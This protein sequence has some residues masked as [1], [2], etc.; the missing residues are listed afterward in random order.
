[1]REFPKLTSL[2]G[3]RRMT[4]A[5]WI[6]EMHPSGVWIDRGPQDNPTRHPVIPGTQLDQSQDIVWYRAID[7]AL[8]PGVHQSHVLYVS[9]DDEAN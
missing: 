7:G 3:R 2:T 6:S 8:V 5:Q 9:E 1:M 4:I